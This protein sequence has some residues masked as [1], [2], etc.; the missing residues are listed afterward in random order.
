MPRAVS[1]W[2]ELLQHK[3][4]QY[5]PLPSQEEGAPSSQASAQHRAR[6]NKL[7]IMLTGMTALVLFLAAIVG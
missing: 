4:H 2:I 6:R 7:F 1:T 3:N 5:G